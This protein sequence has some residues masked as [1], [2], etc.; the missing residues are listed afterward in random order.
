MQ[1]KLGDV[2]RLKSGGPDMTV[3]EVTKDGY[4]VA[5]WYV[6]QVADYHTGDFEPEML[7]PAVDEDGFYDVGDDELSDDDL[8]YLVAQSDYYKNRGH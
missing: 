8:D 3:S 5:M 1:F 6:E 7:E 4:V 2:V